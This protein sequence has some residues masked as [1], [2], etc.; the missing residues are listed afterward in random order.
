MKHFDPK[1]SFGPDVAKLYDDHPR[2]DEAAA[3]EFLFELVQEGDALEFAIGTGRIALPLVAKG[4]PV[5]G[6]ELSP[7]MVEQLH[8]KPGG[9][10]IEVVI[11][12]MSEATTQHRYDLVYLVFNSIFNIL[13]VEGQIR[14]F[15]NA[16]RHLNSDGH[17]VVETAVPHAWILPGQP[18]YV[19]TE[20]I[21]L[22]TVV[23]DVARYDPVTQL[24]EENHVR[25]TTTGIT[26]NPIVCR[27]ITPG[28][29]DLMARLAGLR[30]VA[31]YANWQRTKFDIHSTA[32]ISVYG[33]SNDLTNQ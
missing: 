31:R 25:L 14:C 22:D 9:Q 11:G 7:D 3:V 12:D 15:Q 33:L 27:L 28:E 10:Q 6:I 17:F 20:H 4:V 23:L 19:H 26:M 2:G 16:A 8:A 13:T 1:S 5:D 18:D 29:M 21:G 24:L 30:L 32:H